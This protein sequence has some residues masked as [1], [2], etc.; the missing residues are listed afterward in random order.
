MVCA[1]QSEIRRLSKSIYSVELPCK[2][3]PLPQRLRKRKAVWATV[4]SGR[5]RPV[6]NKHVAF[7]VRLHNPYSVLSA[8]K[9][10]TKV[11]NI[12]A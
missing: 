4:G 6:D 2:K 9:A 5:R 11:A 12:A 1:L 3:P 8:L 7:A 10:N